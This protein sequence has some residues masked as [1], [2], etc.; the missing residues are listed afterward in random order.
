MPAAFSSVA[1]VALGQFDPDLFPLESLVDSKVISKAEAGRSK[2][3]A[4]LPQRVSQ[5]ALP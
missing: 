5:L 2:V 1:I 4:L 3:M